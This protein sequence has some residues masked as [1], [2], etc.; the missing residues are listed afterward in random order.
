MHKTNK[1]CV[2]SDIV[3][4]FRKTQEIKITRRCDPSKYWNNGEMCRVKSG[5]TVPGNTHT[6]YQHHNVNDRSLFIHLGIDITL[7]LCVMIRYYEVATRCCPLRVEDMDRRSTDDQRVLTGSPPPCRWMPSH[8]GQPL[9]RLRVDHR[10]RA[11]LTEIMVWG[12]SSR[13]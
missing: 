1:H 8:R 6:R 13:K 7:Y 4:W 9:P 11:K 3:V 5:I 10:G 12:K 2:N